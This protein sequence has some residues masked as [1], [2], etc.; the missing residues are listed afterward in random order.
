MVAM[1]VVVCLVKAGEE[2]GREKARG[3]DDGV[4]FGLCC[5]GDLGRASSPIVSQQC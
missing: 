3:D 4:Q 2:A 5:G 1:E